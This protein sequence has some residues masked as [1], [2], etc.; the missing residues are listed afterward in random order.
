MDN[1]NI[2]I[3]TNSGSKDSLQ[4][5]LNKIKE[6]DLSCVGQ[7]TIMCP[8]SYNIK[9]HTNING[10]K[11]V[12]HNYTGKNTPFN[13]WLQGFLLYPQYSHYIITQD[14]YTFTVKD[15]DIKMLNAY[16]KSFPTGKGYLCFLTTKLYN[17]T[18]VSLPNGIL[19][20]KSFNISNILQTYYNICETGAN[21]QN[22]F[23]S[24]FI[25]NGSYIKDFKDYSR[26]LYWSI[27]NNTC[28]EYIS[29]FKS[30]DY[31]MA[32]TQIYNC[33]YTKRI[34]NAS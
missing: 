29:N 8:E 14:N 11:V 25:N 5:N 33:K 1:I 10:V 22:S 17:N 4:L 18:H 6:C 31:W 27:P 24:L 30:V 16:K 19:S 21:D 12:Y 7:I 3:A 15:F 28:D 2:I 20:R 34:F 9:K 23:S 13:Q 26:I 32:P